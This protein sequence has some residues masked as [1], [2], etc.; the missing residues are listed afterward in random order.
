MDYNYIEVDKRNFPTLCSGY[1][2]DSKSEVR[3]LTVGDIKLMSRIDENNTT[4][5]IN[6]LIRRCCR[7]T[8]MK[9][10]DLFIADRNYLLM[11]L[12]S[13]SFISANGY[14]IKLDKCIHCHE[15]ITISLRIKR[16]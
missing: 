16:S 9:Y 6:E 8:N 15:P 4:Y 2:A 3:M 13:G 10:E 12:K 11:Y 1:P 7:F 14:D 5:V